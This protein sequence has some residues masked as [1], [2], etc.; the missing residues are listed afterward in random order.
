MKKI[1][2]LS[3]THGFLSPKVHELFEKVD[4]IIHA[5]D[6][7]SLDVLTAL[8]TIAPV[9]AVYGN[10]DGYEIRNR[11]EPFRVFEL[12]DCRIELTHILDIPK[13]RPVSNGT[14]NIKFFGHT[15]QPLFKSFGSI[16]YINP[17]AAGKPS[18]NKMYSAAIV[19]ISEK[20]KVDVDFFKF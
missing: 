12:Y 14:T 9:T 19:T 16:H 7:G 8:E 1:G 17:G 13:S 3:D 11:L 2:V 15:H 18:V 20:R 4:H 6:I 10:M 5:G